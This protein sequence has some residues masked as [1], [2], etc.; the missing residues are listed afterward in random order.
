M[1]GDAVLAK[2]M[3]QRLL[4]EGIYVVSFSYLVVPKG[5]ARIRTQMA[6]AHEITHLEQA[7]AAFAKV[8]KELD[9]IS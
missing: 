2:A 9:V 8:G 7:V 1:L 5:K 4:Q 6:A 3:A